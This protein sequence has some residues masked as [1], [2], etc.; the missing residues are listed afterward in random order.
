MTLYVIG[1][2]YALGDTFAKKGGEGSQGNGLSPGAC[3]SSGPQCDVLLSAAFTVRLRSFLTGRV[4]RGVSACKGGQVTFGKPSSS[5]ML[6]WHCNQS[7]DSTH[8]AVS[9]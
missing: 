4:A 1:V 2:L 3:K 8:S 7:V 6:L 9:V 5:V